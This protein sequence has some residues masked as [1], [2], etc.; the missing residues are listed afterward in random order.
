MRGWATSLTWLKDATLAH[1]DRVRRG[2]ELAWPYVVATGSRAWRKAG[3]VTEPKIPNDERERAEAALHAALSDAARR[4]LAEGVSKEALV[5][6]AEDRIAELRRVL[7]PPETIAEK[8]RR[9]SNGPAD[10]IGDDGDE[11]T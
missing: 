5:R 3:P 10:D 6:Y 11:T 8:S 2:R 7:D 9:G 1:A 4:A